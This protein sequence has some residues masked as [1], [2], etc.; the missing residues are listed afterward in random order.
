MKI[1]ETEGATPLDP[2]EAQ[3]LLPEIATRFELNEYEED[4]IRQALSWAQRSRKLRTDL[5]TVTGLRLLHERMFGNVWAWAGT[6]RRTEKSVGVAPHQ[7]QSQLGTLCQNVAYQIECS[8]LHLD[9]VAVSF[10]HQLTRIHPFPN[11]NGRHARMAADL[12][13]EFHKRKPFSWSQQS[14]LLQ[15]TE[16]TRYIEALRCA[17]RGDIRPLLIFARSE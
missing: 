6:F 7:I 12:L 16:R 5:V 13:L 1:E 2:N 10:H 3:G 4:N 14:L 15:S 17:D 9:E 11:G 8:S